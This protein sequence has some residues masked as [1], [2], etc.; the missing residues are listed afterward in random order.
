MGEGD[1]GSPVGGGWV[2]GMREALWVGEGVRGLREA[3]WVQH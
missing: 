2:R 3:V 1:E